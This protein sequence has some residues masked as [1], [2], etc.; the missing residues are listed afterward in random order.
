MALLVAIALALFV[1]PD[2]W[3]FVAV[4]GS[5]VVEVGE[6]VFWVRWTRRRRAAVGVEALVGRVVEIDADGWAR[7]AGE[8]WRVRGAAP[9][10]RA[11]I[12]GVDGL[13]LVVDPP[14]RDGPRR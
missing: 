10:E 12:A 9:G 4:A 13:T 7:V 11:R 1:L 2:P 5:G 3:G 14:D 6:A 8:R